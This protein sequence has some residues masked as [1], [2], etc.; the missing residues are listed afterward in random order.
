LLTRFDLFVEGGLC[1]RVQL[2]QEASFLS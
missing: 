2:C 1:G